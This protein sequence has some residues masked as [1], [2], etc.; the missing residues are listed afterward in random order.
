[1]LQEMNTEEQPCTA[2]SS[3]C[4]SLRLHRQR[5]ARRFAFPRRQAAATRGS[6]M[7]LH[8]LMGT[9]LGLL[10]PNTCLG[11]RS[12]EGALPGEGAVQML[13]LRANPSSTVDAGP[14]ATRSLTDTVASAPALD[15]LHSKAVGAS[16]AKDPSEPAGGL[17]N[18]SLSTAATYT[19]FTVSSHRD[20][21]LAGTSLSVLLEQLVQHHVGRRAGQIDPNV[22]WP[23]LAVL[24]LGSVLA[25]FYFCNLHTPPWSTMESV[26]TRLQGSRGLS[27]DAPSAEAR[28]SGGAAEPSLKKATTRVKFGFR[29]SYKPGEPN[30]TGGHKTSL[31]ESE[32]T[33][34]L[35]GV[36]ATLTSPSSDASGIDSRR[37]R[38][39]TCD[40]N[41]SEL[42]Q[43]PTV[44]DGSDDESDEACKG[45]STSSASA[46]SSMRRTIGSAKPH[47]MQRMA[48]GK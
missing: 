25:L 31:M 35:P 11:L 28:G 26:G 10:L 37:S 6:A 22:L 15:T 20:S 4:L 19:G 40:S 47:G 42:W 43:D 5:D 9:L 29:E 41:V 24:V 16:S 12:A 27:A 30:D 33:Q 39:S 17:S 23:V 44:G 36:Q 8:V 1:M 34:G 7:P 38:S 18:R 3:V 45:K 46:A 21:P 13:P 48:T 32:E 14:G 2:V